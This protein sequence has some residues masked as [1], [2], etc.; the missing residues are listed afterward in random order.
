M[1]QGTKENSPY[2]I[3]HLCMLYSSSRS[4]RQ[5]LRCHSLESSTSLVTWRQTSIVD[6]LLTKAYCGTCFGGMR[7][8]KES[9]RLAATALRSAFKS[10]MRRRS[11]GLCTGDFLGRRTEV[12]SSQAPSHMKNT[13]KEGRAPATAPSWET[14]CND[15]CTHCEHN[16]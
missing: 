14:R 2:I 16:D 11:L 12:Q 4:L 8:L 13:Q 7:S 15:N 1:S 10:V 9:R 6:L 3:Y 5:K